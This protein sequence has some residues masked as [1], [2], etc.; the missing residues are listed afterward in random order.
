MALQH[1]LR[2]H[3]KL[4]PAGLAFQLFAI[5]L[6]PLSLLLVAITFGSISIHNRAMRNMVGERDQRAVSIAA[7]ALNDQIT[8]R[9]HEMVYLGFILT[10][11]RPKSAESVLIDLSYM[12]TGFDAGVAVFDRD[13][14]IMA[15]K[16]EADFWKTWVGNK[17]DWQKIY[18]TTEQNV[19]YM[20][21]ISNPPYPGQYGLIGIF[22]QDSRILVGAYSIPSLATS[23]VSDLVPPGGQLSIMLVSSDHQILYSQGALSDQSADHPG[24][25]AAL[26]GQTGTT[27][28]NVSGDEHV[29]A[30]SPVT[31]AGWALITEESWQ[32]VSTPTLRTSLIAPLAL[33]PA[34]LIMLLALYLI[35]SQVVRP[36]RRLE[37]KASTLANGDFKAIQEPVGGIVEIRNLQEELVRMAGK[38]RE[39]ERSLH[40]YI[41]SIT[42]AQEEERRRL[43]RELHD[44]TLQAL[45]ALK[46]RVQLAQ[47][48]LQPST[49]PVTAQNVQLDEIAALTEQTMDNLRRLTRDLRPAYLEDL[50]LVPALEMLAHETSQA[51]EIGVEFHRQGTERRLDAGVEL[52]LYR[53]AQEACNNMTRHAQAKHASI[54]I[55]YLPGSVTLHIK[56]DGVGFT[57]LSNPAGYAASGHYGLLGLRERADLMGATLEIHTSPGEG[58]SVF[59]AMPDT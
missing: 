16:G 57:L 5:I 4:P 15:A 48:E 26:N 33:I 50:G 19:G 27:F 22:A 53:M 41:G 58:T 55:N 34:V 54:D 39:A 9:W 51:G 20:T 35:S 52:A 23:S 8:S 21:I 29:T 12:P 44:D 56:D 14:K 3:L 36:L 18:L 1:W 43:A 40:G 11:E 28:V 24:V 37:A 59:V 42:A 2:K 13:G 25:A 6:L 46:Q 17:P 30:Y 10:A 38:V 49:P 7:S 45:I 32:A 31:I 47:L